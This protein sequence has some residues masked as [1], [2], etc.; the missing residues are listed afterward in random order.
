MS[1]DYARYEEEALAEIEKCY[2]NPAVTK[3]LNMNLSNSDDK[4]DYAQWEKGTEKFL[5]A[6]AG[7]IRKWAGL[8][9]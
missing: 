2:D 6:N 8:N 3:A 9:E 4:T 1:S 5:D 7:T